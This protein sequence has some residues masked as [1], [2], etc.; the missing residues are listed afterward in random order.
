MRGLTCSRFDALAWSPGARVSLLPLMRNHERPSFPGRANRR[1]NWVHPSDARSGVGR[2]SLSAEHTGPDIG[3]AG[4]E[5]W[6]AGREGHGIPHA[7]HRGRGRASAC[8]K[9]G[10]R[11]ARTRGA[12]PWHPPCSPSGECPVER[13]C[14]G[15]ATP[16]E[17]TRM[18][19]HGIPHAR[20]RGRGRAGRMCQG[21]ATPS[22]DKRKPGRKSGLG[23]RSRH[24]AS[25]MAS[26]HARHR[27]IGT[28]RVVTACD[29]GRDGSCAPGGAPRDVVGGIGHRRRF[30][31]PPPRKRGTH[32][33]HMRE[34][35]SA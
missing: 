8:V 15:R 23:H 2:A 26:P 1:Q 32:A 10:Q 31:R 14:Q 17:D 22:E 20:R 5:A 27:G 6:P 34:R 29:K 11:P 18:P 24:G 13:M 3:P 7:R 30:A 19:G 35:P 21:R 9:A 16:S 33:R 4:H 28:G 12:G 25:P